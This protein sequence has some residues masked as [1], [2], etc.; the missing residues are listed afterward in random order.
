M[1][2]GSPLRYA[3]ALGCLNTGAWALIIK[4]ARVKWNMF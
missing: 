3:I 1:L 4:I 2:I